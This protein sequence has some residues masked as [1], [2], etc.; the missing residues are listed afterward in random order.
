[1]KILTATQMREVDRLTTER[2]GVPSLILMEN[3]GHG[4]VLEME[5]HFGSLKGE[6]I[7]I[8]CGKGNNGGDGFVVARHLIM[9]GQQP[10]VFLFA[11]PEELKGEVLIN[12]EIL[13]KMGVPVSQV[14][15]DELAADRFESYIDRW[16]D[17]IVVDGLLGTG[18]RLPLTGTM[19][20]VVRHLE[21]LPRVVSIDVPSGVES[22][23][24][25]FD[26]REVVAAR[27][28]LTVTF[29]APKPSHIFYPAADFAGEWVVVPIG[30]PDVLLNQPQYWLNALT[31][32]EAAR[33]LKKL[34]RQPE[35][36]KGSFGHVL[37]VCGSVGKTGAAGMTALSALRAGAGLAT[38]ALPEPCLPIV[39]ALAM[40]FMT[41]PLEATESGSVS[42]KAFDYGRMESL[43]DGKDVVAVGP[44]LGTHLETVEFVQRLLRETRLPLVLDADGINAFAGKASLLNGEGR[45][46][47][48]T[49]HPGE[50]SRL[51][52]ISTREVLIK[53]IEL[54]RRFAMEHQLHL[55][56]KGHRTLYATPVGQVHVNLSGNAGMATGG[57][58]DVLTGLV[59]GLLAQA[60]HSAVPVEEIVAL[61]VYLHGLAGDLARDDVGEQA[62]IASDLLDFLP[63]A[64]ARLGAGR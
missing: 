26:A 1:M 12:F 3:A 6:R 22:D 49:P 45:T 19:A 40:E 35:S 14:S 61:S 17:C 54:V 37:A 48:L 27:A 4:V 39:A 10:Q 63:Q 30:T 15:E 21:R 33:V 25:A 59:A 29:T 43:L 36:H 7:V 44:G 55:V 24:L 34:R 47:V 20:K 56:L 42:L 8:L 11:S 57:A 38:V 23:S 13:K 60:R 31:G 5:R 18:V 2:Y 58:G 52:G 28:K 32:V 41:E 51:L 9:G 53:R 46:L 64:F 62:L 50:F 16:A